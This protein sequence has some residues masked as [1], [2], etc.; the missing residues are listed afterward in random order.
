MDVGNRFYTLAAVADEVKMDLGEEG[1][2]KDLKL[3][4]WAIAGYKELNLAAPVAVKTCKLKQNAYG[5]VS[6]PNDYIT[7]TKIG[8]RYAKKVVVVGLTGGVGNDLLVQQSAAVAPSSVYAMRELSQASATYDFMNYG[9]NTVRGYQFGDY[10]GSYEICDNQIQFHHNFL[11]LPV[12]LEYVTDG[13][14][15]GGDIAIHPFFV[16]YIRAYIHYR[17]VKA[18]DHAP[19][20]LKLEKERDMK[21][22]KLEGAMYKYAES[23]TPEY[24]VNLTRVAGNPIIVS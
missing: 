7:Y 9:G 6:L 11:G 12:Y 18:D 2:H 24:I 8:V 10:T 20:S 5:S 1:T 23:F 22:A 17:R 4:Q 21:K 19:Q 16:K 15:C 3:L 14:D 13:L